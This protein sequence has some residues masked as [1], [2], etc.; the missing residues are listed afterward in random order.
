MSGRVKIRSPRQYQVSPA[1]LQQC[2]E[3]GWR[4]I[5]SLPGFFAC[6]NGNILGPNGKI[7]KQNIDAKR[8]SRTYLK[9]LGGAYAMIGAVDVF[10]VQRTYVVNRL[11]CE[12]FH[13]Q[14]P[15]PHHE[16]AHWNGNKLDNR[17]SNLRWAT[18]TENCADRI[19]HGTH[20]ARDT[21]PRATMTSETVAAI[22]R[23]HA[24][25]LAT[26]ISQGKTQVPKGFRQTLAKRHGIKL[27]AV[28]DVIIGRCW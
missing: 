11:V 4:P 13:G 20:L 6:A 22:R 14:P 21:H 19:R 10:G 3:L 25:A 2:L 28:K 18:H 1:Y 15:T 12:A 5:P 23:E 7:R 27:S 8:M 9:H 17:A 16:A 26:R 24:E